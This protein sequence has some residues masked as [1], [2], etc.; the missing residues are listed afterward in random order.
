MEINRPAPLPEHL[1]LGRCVAHHPARL[2]ILATSDLHAHLRSWDYL[3]NCPSPAVGLARTASLI[4]KARAE[5]GCCLLVD[6][7][8]FL[9]GSPLGDA[10]ALQARGGQGALHP[11]IS[12][13]NLLRYDAANLGNHEFSHGLEFLMGHLAGA[14]FP[15]IS[16]NLV[17][18]LGPN[19]IDDVRLVPPS[20]IITRH[21][22]DQNGQIHPL[23]VGFVG[24]AP[25]QTALWEGA[26]LGSKLYGRDILEAAIAHVPRLRAQGADVVIALSH[27]GIGAKT[28]APWMENASAALAGI[29][30]IDALVTGHT[31]QTFPAPFKASCGLLSGK[32]AVMPG[33]YGS[34]LGVID[35]DLIWRAGRWQVQGGQSALW[36]IS[37]R[38]SG[39]AL[40]ALA[41]NAPAIV[42]ASSM[43]HRA[44]RAWVNQPVGHSF[45]ALHSYFAMIGPSPAL[46]LVARAQA[47]HVAQ[48]LVDGPYAH[49]PILSAAAPFHAGGRGGPDNFVDIPPGPLTLRHV[50]DLYP[51]PNTVAALLVTGA[52]VRLWLERSF[53]QF[54]QI[55]P[56]AQDTPLL[57]PDFPSFNFDTIEGLTWVVDLSAPPWVDAKGAVS[58]PPCRILKLSYQGK[59]LAA[60][61]PFVLAT[62]SYRASGSGGFVAANTKA[63]SLGPALSSRDALV[64]YIAQNGPVAAD[65]PPHWHFVPMAGT[66]VLFDSSARA[67]SHLPGLAPHRACALSLTPQGFRR[68]RLHL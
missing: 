39:G 36:P 57:D 29:D 62:N 32:P 14:Q 4:A 21:L 54:P 20:V 22:A 43:A 51:H 23:R 41:P 42:L 11:M 30:G 26:K 55:A 65:A 33:F 38:S 67:D 40:R 68:F 47:A 24:F 53:S 6:N 10:E 64:A 12:A 60:D 34:H 25:P 5:V 31:H 49:L 61:Q 56:H 46:G 7:G 13:M 3:K 50:Y 66:T 48:S 8:D 35:L 2:R 44:T 52:Q 9:Q 1:P 63:L 27:S 19:P 45:H 17:H 37:R 15:A 28:A 58:R 16:S 18:H 59:P